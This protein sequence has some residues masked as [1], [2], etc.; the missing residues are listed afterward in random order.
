MSEGEKTQSPPNAVHGE[1]GTGGLAR[2][3]MMD[4]T[5]QIVVRMVDVNDI[6]LKTHSNIP[7]IMLIISGHFFSVKTGFFIT[8]DQN[9]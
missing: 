3:G 7:K 6:A 1:G 4:Q 8:H 9:R 2:G 5:D